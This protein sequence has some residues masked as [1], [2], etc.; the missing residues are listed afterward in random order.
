MFLMKNFNYLLPLSFYNNATTKFCQFNW[1]IWKISALISF[2][3]HLLYSFQLQILR[4]LWPWN[5]TLPQARFSDRHLRNC[6]CR[7]RCRNWRC[8]NWTSRI[9]SSLSC[10]CCNRWLS[11]NHALFQKLIARFGE[12]KSHFVVQV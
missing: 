4:I 11:I 10:E 1:D 2:F 9:W 6:L 7:M 8:L 12:S 5:Y 3:D